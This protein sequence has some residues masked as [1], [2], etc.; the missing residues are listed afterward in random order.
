MFESEELARIFVG[1]YGPEPKPSIFFCPGRVNLIGE[2]IDYNGGLVMPA[3]LTMGTY[4]VAAL[5]D[6]Q[7]IELNSL[8]EKPR[9]HSSVTCELIYDAKDG[10]ANYPKGV[11]ELLKRA[12]VKIPGLSIL[13]AS[14]LPLR[15]GLSSSASIEVLTGFMIRSICKPDSDIDR[16]ELAKLCQK[17]E[18]EFL[19]VRSGIM[20]QFSVAMGRRDHC[21]LLNCASLEYRH[22]RFDLPDTI[23][24]IM[25]TNHQ[26]SLSES[27]YNQRRQECDQALQLLRRKRPALSTLIDAS[28]VDI[29]NQIADPVLKRRARHVVTEQR[30]VINAAAALEERRSVDFGALLTASHDSLRDDFEVTGEQLD[31]IVDAARSHAGCLGAR[32]TGAGFGGCA[33]ALVQRDQAEQFMEH[34]A[35]MYCERLGGKASLY[36]TGFE[37][38][39]RGISGL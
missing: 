9:Y 38:G 28:L 17:V 8:D 13:Y 30:R 7:H 15:A 34:V 25:D 11:I 5:R 3:A 2:H 35:T 39:V 31:A 24:V 20:D 4:G 26:R 19:G 14:T 12:G 18:N 16:I 6:D 37:D 36:L 29:E 10:W 21:M 33:I 1:M 32:M 22:I 23:L 27:R